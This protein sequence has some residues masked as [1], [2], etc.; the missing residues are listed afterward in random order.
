MDVKGEEARGASEATIAWQQEIA[1][2]LL[3]VITALAT[4]LFIGFL[5]IV[6]E[7]QAWGM[8]AISVAQIGSNALM[9]RMRRWPHGLRAGWLVGNL[10]VTG[11]L[12]ALPGYDRGVMAAFLIG[13]TFTASI[14]LGLR[15]AIA[16]FGC[17]TAALAF[18]AWG[19]LAGWMPPPPIQVEPAAPSGWLTLWFVLALV[20]TVGLIAAET[21]FRR[22][23][24]LLASQQA[25]MA[26]K[27]A[28][29]RALVEAQ[30]RTQEALEKAQRTEAERE[31]LAR[32]LEQTLAAAGAGFWETDLRS[33]RVRW[34]DAMY[35]VL[36]Y[37]PGAVTPSNE[38]WRERTHPADH[39]RMM[40]AP[41]VDGSVA[42]YRAILPNGEERWLRSAMQVRTDA[43]GVPFMLRGI[44]SD[45]T[46]ERMTKQQ[47]ARLAEVANR[48]SNGVV[49]T[50]LDA[51]I[52]WINEGFSRITGWTLEETLGKK[53]GD[54]LQG[55]HTDRDEL[56]RIRAAIAGRQPFQ[57][58][59]LNYHKDGSQYWIHF[60]VRP[61]LDDDGQ[62]T[63]FV[64]I[65]TDVTERRLAAR[66][67]SLAQRI[68]AQLLASQSITE[69]A[70]RLVAELVA[71]LDIVVA[72]LWLVEP[73]KASLTYL[74]GAA[75]PSAGNHG[76]EFLARTRELDFHPGSAFVAGVGVPGMAW[77]TRRSAVLR[78]IAPEG[79][80]HAQSRRQRAALQAGLQTFCATPILGPE[81]VLGVLEIGGTAYYPGHESIPGL[82]ERVAEQVAS[83]LRHEQSRRAFETVFE[84]SP[85]GLLLVNENGDIRRLNTR[86]SDL[87]GAVAGARLEA[88][89][90]GAGAFFRE[91][92]LTGRL[93]N[94]ETRGRNGNFAAE[95]SVARTV[96]NRDSHAIVAIRDLTERNR[97]E[98]ALN[99]S[100]RE[101]EML[102]KEVHHRVKNNLQIVAS[103]LTLQAEGL[104][105]GPA[106]EALIETVYRVR[107]MSAVHQQLYGTVGL[108]RIDLGEYATRLCRS[109]Q[110][111]IAP[112]AHLSISTEVVEVSIE[113]AVP[114]GLILNELI[115]N[116]LKHGRS[117]DGACHM[118]LTLTRSG[119]GF[120]LVLADRGRGFPVDRANAA[121]LG[122]QL[123]RSLSR[124]LRGRVSLA[125][126]DGAKVTLEVPGP[127]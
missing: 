78:E 74:A 24:K 118:M 109:L 61:S 95:I 93:F 31:S 33:G 126:E 76:E 66:R 5:P 86:A 6:V 51:R 64:A 22:S 85:D 56:V 89:V 108:D 115:T 70:P 7:A 47:I 117:P 69:A 40:E 10:I 39:A 46:S 43:Q 13:G 121:S 41:L 104:E 14:L 101:K 71:E 49:V 72:Q 35:R 73:G 123:I 65:E 111:S 68:A 63:G 2:T 34:S 80:Q 83:F 32:A 97:M 53:P 60:E 23:R 12:S 15:G 91:A 38:I 8:L 122:M 100:L 81:G 3:W 98:Q 90:E 45:I 106:H 55:P 79:A 36:G 59:L 99:Q 1:T 20:T 54:F 58:E 116:S 110:L 105:G 30:A 107:S 92:T 75:D 62:V 84:E 42:E 44:V 27:D 88:V 94:S 103:L 114:C 82:L 112:D 96:G 19:S 11:L 17:V 16:V 119:E 102:L 127:L 77:G 52:L 37:E 57:T 21:G 29:V 28:S 124:Q 67:D 120:S 26:D 125:S 9:A 4:L 50:D 87:L 25:A 113:N 48:T 18:I